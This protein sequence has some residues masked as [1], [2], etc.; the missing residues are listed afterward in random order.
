M[1]RADETVLEL[2]FKV[3]LCRE[4]AVLFVAGWPLSRRAASALSIRGEEESLK[5][6]NG[7]SLGSWCIKAPGLW[8]RK[9]S[10]LLELFCS[11]DA[12]IPLLGLLNTKQMI[13]KTRRMKNG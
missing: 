2:L 6:A 5:F 13:G 4:F 3:E 8:G 1:C 10:R 9:L 7:T 11:I 12:Y